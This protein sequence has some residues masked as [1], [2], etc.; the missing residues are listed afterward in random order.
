MWFPVDCD[1]PNAKLEAGR[2][3]GKR[4]LCACP[5]GQAVGDNANIVSVVGLS[6]GKIQ[7]VAEDSANRRTHRVQNTK[8]LV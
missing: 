8:R 5:T 6:I 2:Y 3:L 7:D 4:C 1:A